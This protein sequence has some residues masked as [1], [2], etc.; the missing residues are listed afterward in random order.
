MNIVFRVDASLSIGS[1]HVMRC[2]T[3]ARALRERGH[4]C[5]FICRE[6]PGNLN[7]TLELENFKVFRL[8]VDVCQDKELHHADWLGSSQEADAEICKKY[9]SSLNADWL[10]VDHY[11]LDFRWEQRVNPNKYRVLVIDDL[12]DR[13]HACDI[14][15][16]QNL[17]KKEH[18][19]AK[20]VDESCL[21]L[22]GPSNSLLRPEFANCREKSL[23]RRKLGQ[24]EEILITLGGVDVNNNTGLLLKALKECNLPKNVR[25]V[26]VMGATAPHIDEVR[27]IAEYSLW[28]MEVLCGIKDMAER[29]ASADLAISAGG[30]TSWE[31]C[32]VGLPT[33]LVVMAENQKFASEALRAHG[34]A[35]IIDLSLPLES[36]LCA[37]LH[38]LQNP[39]ALKEMSDAAAKICDGSGILNIIEAL[40]C[41]PKKQ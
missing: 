26:V 41:F 12:A 20:L 15:L 27:K 18:H 16:D 36:Q 1:G 4:Q 3:L 34:A 9:I 25:I 21:V 40:E 28:P 19:Y 24:L 14:L 30:G 17:G 22:T 2:L 11:A 8:P 6:H 13:V 39:K 7:A 31:R 10:V 33:L 32:A 23:E 38:K 29:M 5:M 35:E 37:A